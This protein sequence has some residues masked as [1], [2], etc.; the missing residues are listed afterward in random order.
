MRSG[1]CANVANDSAAWNAN[2]R[3]IIKLINTSK[4]KYKEEEE[5]VTR[6]VAKNR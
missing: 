3:V 1:H 4:Q 5:E 6:V 2:L